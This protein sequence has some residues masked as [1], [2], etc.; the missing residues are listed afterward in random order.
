[1]S[2][3]L[4]TLYSL[5]LTLLMSRFVAVTQQYATSRYP[6]A[7]LLLRDNW[8]P[9]LS[10]SASPHASASHTHLQANRSQVKGAATPGRTDGAKRP[11]AFLFCNFAH[12][13]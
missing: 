5:I 11:A 7:Q 12:H 3:F 2:L 13:F 1:M 6:S 8:A 4:I 10:V 9:R